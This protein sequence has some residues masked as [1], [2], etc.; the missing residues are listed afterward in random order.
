[1]NY[2][3]PHHETRLVGCPQPNTEIW[4]EKETFTDSMQDKVMHCPTRLPCIGRNSALEIFH[5]F[6]PQVQASQA[7]PTVRFSGSCAINQHFKLLIL[8]QHH[9][10]ATCSFIKAWQTQGFQDGMNWEIKSGTGQQESQ[11]PA[12]SSKS[13][14][15]SHLH[16]YPGL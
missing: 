6:R 12:F 8:Q 1:M 15:C 10:R 14:R 11:S 16:Y 13:T 3:Q 2:L 9:V 7:M 5:C 4:K